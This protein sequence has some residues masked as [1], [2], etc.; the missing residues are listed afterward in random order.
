MFRYK[1]KQASLPD[2]D[3][4]ELWYPFVVG[5]R[6]IITTRQIAREIAERSGATE[7]DVIGILHNLGLVVR[8]HLSAGDRVILNGFGGLKINARARGNGVESEDKVSATHSII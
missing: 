4:K 7:G 8:A 6:P 1:K 3:G 2:K 5:E